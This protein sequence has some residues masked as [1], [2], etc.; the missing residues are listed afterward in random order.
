MIE[1][2]LV[3]YTSNPERTV[4]IAARTCVNDKSYEFLRDELTEKDVERIVSNVISKN[5]LSVLEHID[6]TFSISGVSGVLTH[7]LVRH[8]IASYSQLS[9]QRTDSSELE[10]TIPPDVEANK[11]LVRE[12]KNTVE[13]CRELY[14]KL[15]MN[16]IPCG[17]AR[18]VLPSSS[19]TKIMTTM[20]ARS[21]FN[22]FSQRE[23]YAEEWEFRQLAR[24]MHI[25]LMKITPIIFRYAGPPCQTYSRCPEGRNILNCGGYFGVNVIQKQNMADSSISELTI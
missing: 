23:C 18:Y 11:D 16:G 25:E 21:L 9:Q 8:R 20:N 4:A 13:Q 12:Y 24:L 17:S 22:L 1:V 10:F 6:F 3:N 14:K 19:N 7:Q 15:I 2:K 5:H